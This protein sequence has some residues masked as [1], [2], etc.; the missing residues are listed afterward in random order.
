MSEEEKSKTCFFICPIG[1]E[2]SKTRRRSDQVL[3]HIIAP[4]VK[5]CDYKDPVRA[6]AI[7]QPG[8]IT[9]QVI[10][11]VY[12][13]DLVVADL[14]EH[15]P[16]V[17]YELAIRHAAK[18]PVIMIMET[19]GIIPFDV[20]Q[21]RV[22]FYDYKDLDSA[23]E[24]RENIVKQIRSI[25]EEPLR[26][27]SPVSIAMDIKFLRE[28]GDSQKEYFGDVLEI[29]HEIRSTLSA[30]PQRLK[31]P[32][33]QYTFTNLS[34]R[35]IGTPWGEVESGASLDVIPPAGVITHAAPAKNPG[36]KIHLFLSDHIG[37]NDSLSV[38]SRRKPNETNM[39]SANSQDDK[40][41]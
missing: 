8:N 16:N 40:V 35:T 18:K 36:R 1:P 37:I 7:A 34:D 27:D 31:V 29:L 14:T 41:K 32:E 10:Q 25:E 20:A 28:S 38:E 30:L 24:C 21:D 26:V 9:S 39:E 11:N 13:A 15:N 33:C 19:G 2:E 12:D 17:F 23:D 3:K 5:E 6:D 4:A 22:I